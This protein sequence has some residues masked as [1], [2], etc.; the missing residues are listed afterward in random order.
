MHNET[1]KNRPVGWALAAL[2]ELMKKIMHIIGILFT[3]Y[4]GFGVLLFVIQRSFIYFPTEP[5]A[6]GYD[7]VV[8]ENG[9]E[10]TKSI[11]LNSGNRNAILYF[12]GNAEAVAHSASEFEYEFP[13]YSV[14]LIN[15]RGYG[16]SSG[17]P[18]EKALYSDA[19]Y[20]FDQL[21][22]L[23]D[24]VSVIGRSL[25]SGVASYIASE[26]DVKKLVLVTPFD[27]I[28]SV[29]QKRFPL[30]PMSILLT[31]KFNSSGRASKINS[32]VLILAAENDQVIGGVHTENLIK[33][34]TNSPPS[35][36]IIEDSGHNDI[37]HHSKYYRTIR[38][39]LKIE[40][41]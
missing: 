13:F 20:I 37:S 6:H 24:S 26:R 16:G 18:E 34:F 40:D 17:K 22:T 27:S 32:E 15:Y 33:S 29:A 39:F 23:Y 2:T 1:R 25:G 12:G 9:G 38:D 5:V 28:Q 14:Y 10:H 41:S 3:C 31:D 36:E 11:L 21:S 19:L 35:V 8:F 7:E 30:Y 4:V